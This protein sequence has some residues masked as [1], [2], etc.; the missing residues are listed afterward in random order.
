[1][2]KLLQVISIV[3]FVAGAL[4]LFQRPA[5]AYA[6]PGTGL[7]AIQAAGSALVATGW[8]LRRKIRA[9]FDRDNASALRAEPL[10]GPKEGE[11][12]SLP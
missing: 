7:L 1:M 6:D 5:Y 8:Y 4:V 3:L 12:S 10:P 11:G 9:L 2:R